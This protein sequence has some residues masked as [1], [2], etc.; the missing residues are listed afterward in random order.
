MT[1]ECIQLDVLLLEEI[2]RS[3]G[4]VAYYWYRYGKHA[5]ESLLN[6]R[7]TCALTTCSNCCQCV[8]RRKQPRR[9]VCKYKRESVA[10][11]GTDAV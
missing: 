6:G 7:L 3:V 10:L 5:T 8:C 4:S 11:T 1:S 2:Y 9:L